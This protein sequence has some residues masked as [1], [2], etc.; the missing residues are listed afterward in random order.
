MAKGYEETRKGYDPMGKGSGSFSTIQACQKAV[1]EAAKGPGVGSTRP[2]ATPM[3][4]GLG[5]VR[6]VP[7]QHK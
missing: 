4:T 7:P 6:R 3:G 1:D 2:K 5:G